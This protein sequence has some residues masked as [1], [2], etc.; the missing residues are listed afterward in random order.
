MFCVVEVVGMVVLVV[1]ENF[2]EIFFFDQ[3][4]RVDVD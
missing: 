4:D 1:V 3:F 2:L